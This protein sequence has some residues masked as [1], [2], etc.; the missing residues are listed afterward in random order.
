MIVRNLI[1]PRPEPHDARIEFLVRVPESTPAGARVF[2]TGGHARLGAWRADGLELAP[3]GSGEYHAEVDLPRSQS[4]EFKLT[5]GSWGSVERSDHGAEIANRRAVVESGAL[6]MIT[7]ARWANDDDRVAGPASNE[8]NRL[9]RHPGFYAHG[10]RNR[11]DL[12]VHLPPGYH[13]EPDRRY[14]VLY[15]QDGQNLFD[16]ATSHGG[17]AWRAGETADRLVRDDAIEPIIIVGVANTP[18]RLHEYTPFADPSLGAGGGADDYVRFLIEEVKPFVDDRYRT[19]PGRA[20]TAIGGSSLGAVTSLH[21]CMRQPHVFSMCIAMSPSL[22]WGG[23][24]LIDRLVQHSAWPR[25]VRLWLDMGT[26]ETCGDG[27]S[28]GHAVEMVRRLAACLR[29]NGL[30]E[31]RDFIHAE[32][33]GGAHHESAWADRLDRVLRFLFAAGRAERLTEPVA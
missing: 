27:E 17:V 18:D 6:H 31:G 23:H 21:A 14:P 32:V 25:H 28:P 26:E 8:P 29:S 19:R 2:I 11:R 12:W 4:I 3:L 16:P 30:R 1:P 33:V 22:W 13:D 15:M 10:L 7:V 9:L 24:A 5:R 20:D